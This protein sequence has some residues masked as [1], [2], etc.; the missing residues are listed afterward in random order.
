MRK[1]INIYNFLFVLS[2]HSMKVRVD[3]VDVQWVW[4][5]QVGVTWQNPNTFD[6][7]PEWTVE[8]PSS[9]V[10]T[11]IEVHRSIFLISQTCQKVTLR[12]LTCG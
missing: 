8:L 9:K 6:N 5:M 1:K 2:A 7:L 11:S 4:T 3:E 10:I 12:Q